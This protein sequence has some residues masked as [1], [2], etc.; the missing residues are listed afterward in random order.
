ML[1]LYSIT[2]N[3]VPLK[4]FACFA[5]FCFIGG[6]ALPSGEHHKHEQ[7]RFPAAGEGAVAD[8][9]TAGVCA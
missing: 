3:N 5:R 1:P 9:G 8:T 7:A 6:V 4:C 2:Y